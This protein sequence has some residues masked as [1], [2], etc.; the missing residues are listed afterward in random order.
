MCEK[1]K[2]KNY[3]FNGMP[4]RAGGFRLFSS[5][6]IPDRSQ[7]SAMGFGCF[8]SGKI[9]VFS[10]DTC[11]YSFEKCLYF[12]TKERS[13]KRSLLRCPADNYTTKREH[14]N[15]LKNARSFEPEN[16]RPDRFLKSGEGVFQD[17]KSLETI[18][19]ATLKEKF[20]DNE[21]PFK[22]VTLSLTKI[23][24]EKAELSNNS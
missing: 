5:F 11:L 17:C 8:F 6:T 14:E 22:L 18:K 7:S 13:L 16:G 19:T 9:C 4:E 20:W 21:Y 1:Q 23:R 3:L 24:G 2:T 12:T 10:T 15:R